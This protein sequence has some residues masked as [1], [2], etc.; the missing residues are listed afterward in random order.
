MDY[1]KLDLIVSELEEKYMMLSNDEA[2]KIL[3]LTQFYRI[4]RALGD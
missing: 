4:Q 2:K 3:A 1:E